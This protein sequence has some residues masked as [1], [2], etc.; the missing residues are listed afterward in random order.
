[1]FFQLGT[2]GAL[3]MLM[4]LLG[5]RNIT[6]ERITTELEYESA[7]AA[8]GAAFIGGPVA[9]AYSRFDDATRGAAHGEYLA[10]IA[11]WRHGQGYRIP[12]E[13]VVVRGEK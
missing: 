2:G 7:D 3:E 5:Y 4:E 13:F 8:L 6:A 1:M 12:G 10:S 11:A 9:M